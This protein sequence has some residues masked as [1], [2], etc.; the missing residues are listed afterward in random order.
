MGGQLLDRFDAEGAEGPFSDFADAGNFAYGERGEKS[1]FH[2][3]GY[4]DEA[5]GFA[6]IGGDLGGETRRG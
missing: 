5:A 2:A 6:L 4:P 1:G 3:W